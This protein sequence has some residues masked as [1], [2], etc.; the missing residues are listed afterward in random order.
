MNMKK[1]LVKI[2]VVTMIFSLFAVTTVG[3]NASDETDPPVKIIVQK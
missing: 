2:L 1:L 3:V